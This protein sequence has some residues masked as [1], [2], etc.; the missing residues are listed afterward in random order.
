MRGDAFRRAVDKRC[1]DSSFAKNVQFFVVGVV[2][3]RRLGESF[4]VKKNIST[5]LR[6]KAAYF[7]RATVCTVYN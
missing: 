3:K 5:E 1:R 6:V 2:A 4:I 7:M